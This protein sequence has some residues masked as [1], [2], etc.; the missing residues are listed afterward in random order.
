[1]GGAR[2]VGGDGGGGGT[3]VEE[4]GW[5]CSPP[6]RP[7]AAHRGGGTRGKKD[8][9]GCMEKEDAGAARVMRKTSGLLTRE[10]GVGHAIR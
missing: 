9:W 10:E 2:A 8:G 4:D 3:H 5:G 6:P 1:M 7:Q